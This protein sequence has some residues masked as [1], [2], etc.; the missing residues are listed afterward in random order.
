MLLKIFMP[1]TQPARLR[2]LISIIT[3]IETQ[4]AILNE[5]R[6]P[7]EFNSGFDI[8]SEESKGIRKITFFKIMQNSVL[9]VYYIDPYSIIVADKLP[10][11]C[12]LA[13]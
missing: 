11:Y 2:K 7:E 5:F 1:N 9:N 4:I 3:D 13:N 8:N 10:I 6:I 12:I